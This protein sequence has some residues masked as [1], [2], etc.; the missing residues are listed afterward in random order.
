MQWDTKREGRYAIQ[1][2]GG[3]VVIRGCDFW[4]AGKNHVSIGEKVI[5]AIVSEN[6]VKGQVQIDNKC[7]NTY[8]E[9]NLGTPQPPPGEQTGRRPRAQ[10]E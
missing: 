9:G 5:R 6:T 4:E 2:T 3:T 10:Q 8:I 7:E 1:A